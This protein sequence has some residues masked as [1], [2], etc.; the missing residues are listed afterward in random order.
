MIFS[1][2]KCT[3]QVIESV[4]CIFFKLRE[5]ILLLQMGHFITML[6]PC[7]DSQV[8]FLLFFLYNKEESN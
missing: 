7:L 1:V 2:I 6:R 8:D 5:Y 4:R 3:L